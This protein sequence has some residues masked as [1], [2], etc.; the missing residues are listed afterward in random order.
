MQTLGGNTVYSGLWGLHRRSL[1]HRASG[2]GRDGWSPLETSK[3][4]C[5]FRIRGW[6]IALWPV[7]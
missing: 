7:L 3:L 5:P 4:R 2:D 1:S 6:Q